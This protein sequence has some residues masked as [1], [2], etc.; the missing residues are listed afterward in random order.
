LIKNLNKSGQTGKWA[1][2]F[3]RLTPLDFFWSRL[4]DDFPLSAVYRFFLEVGVTFPRP[5]NLVRGRDDSVGGL[6]IETGA[7]ECGLGL[8]RDAR[9]NSVFFSPYCQRFYLFMFSAVPDATL[10]R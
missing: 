3:P 9:L 5:P 6:G 4:S 7:S 2:R 10:F 8:H 1:A